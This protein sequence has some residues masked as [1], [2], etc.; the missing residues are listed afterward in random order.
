MQLDKKLFGFCIGGFIFVGIV[1]VLMHFAYD[2]SGQNPLVGLVAAVNESTWEHMKLVFFPM[3]AF[4]IY[5]HIKLNEEYPD[6]IYGGMYATVIGTFAIPVLFYGYQ[7][8]LGETNA[9]INILIF[10]V[11]VLIGMVFNYLLADVCKGE[12]CQIVALILTTLLMAGFFI[13]TSIPPEGLLF[14]EPEIATH[15]R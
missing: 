6:I 9:V 10:F 12:I 13:F 11:S 5:Q 15:K 3:L 4:V 7:A 8:V 1:G 2:W 14:Q